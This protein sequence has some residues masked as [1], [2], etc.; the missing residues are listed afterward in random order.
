MIGGNTNA[1]IQVMD[2]EGVNELGERI[3]RWVDVVSIKGFLDYMSG[4]ND[5]ALN[6]KIQDTTHMFLCDFDN[7]ENLQTNGWLWDPFSFKDGIIKKQN[8]KVVTVTSKNAR[9]C[10][11]G[12]VYDILMID[13]PMGLHQHLE[14]YLKYI[15]VGQGVS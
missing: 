8:D 9:M 3:N 5:Y 6:A 7:L 10:I 14:I 4:Q 12:N 1:I 13:D 11:N 2:T 15:G